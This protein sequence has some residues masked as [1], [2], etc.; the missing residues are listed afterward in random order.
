MATVLTYL[1]SWLGLAV[2]AVLNALIREKG[3]SHLISPMKARQVSTV[4]GF[5]LF[6]VCVWLLARVVP[7]SSGWL[8]LVIA[9]VWFG[10]AVALEPLL[11]F[12]LRNVSEVA[13]RDYDLFL[14]KLWAPMLLWTWALRLF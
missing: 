12:L 4:I 14:V 6:S 10:I 1:S 2:I 3:Y 11:P 5:C 8:A 7:I 9:G 13:F